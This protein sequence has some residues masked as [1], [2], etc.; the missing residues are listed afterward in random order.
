MPFGK[1]VGL[2]FGAFLAYFIVLPG[3]ILYTLQF[4]T[5]PLGDLLRVFAAVV[6]T[7]AAIAIGH[8][9]DVL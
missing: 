9:I 5:I 8:F 2:G 4:S 7:A 1:I 6:V 3:D